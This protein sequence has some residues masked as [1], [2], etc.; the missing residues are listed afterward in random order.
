MNLTLLIAV[1]VIAVTVAAVLA[2]R[3]W[4]RRAE[5]RGSGP[6]ATPEPA[7]IVLAGR[8]FRR[9]ALTARADVEF[10]RLTFM[11]GIENPDPLPGETL[12]DYE[13][14]L[15]KVLF[16]KRLL[17]PL[18]GCMFLP[19]EAPKW[20]LAVASETAEFLGDLDEPTDK[21]ALWAL[22]AA[23]LLPFFTSVLSSWSHSLISGSVIPTPPSPS[24]V[25][26]PAIAASTAGGI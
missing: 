20:S 10:L 14:R 26:S 7:E 9:Q 8:R 4:I 17:F 1:L 16:Q 18:V 11:A 13:Q 25:P 12:G 5:Q 2:R 19:I 3:D 6:L 22:V 24:A 23:A 15:V 21:D